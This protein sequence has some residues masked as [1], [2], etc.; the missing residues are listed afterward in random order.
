M[1]SASPRVEVDVLD[2]QVPVRFQDFEA[3]LFFFLIGFLIG[4]ELLD[5]RGA[6]K[7]VVGNRRVLED[8]GYPVIPTAVFGGVIAR[9][10]HADF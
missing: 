7:I 5:Q 3:A 1:W 6:V 9:N 2:R 8:D 10:G 4:I